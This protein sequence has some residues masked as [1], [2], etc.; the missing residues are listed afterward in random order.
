MVYLVELTDHC[1]F[2]IDNLPLFF[3]LHPCYELPL[4]QFLLLLPLYGKSCRA[5]CLMQLDVFLAHC[6]FHLEIIF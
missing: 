6:I 3:Y 2:A 1:L 4:V 5:I